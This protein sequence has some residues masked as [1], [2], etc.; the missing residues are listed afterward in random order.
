M[1]LEAIR[2]ALNL[3]IDRAN[4]VIGSLVRIEERQT[5]V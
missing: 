2:D 4:A 5:D 3:V 1:A